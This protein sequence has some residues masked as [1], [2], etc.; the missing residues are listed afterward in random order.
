LR[1]PSIE[2]GQEKFLAGWTAD[3]II[4]ARAVEAARWDYLRKNPD[5]GL[6]GTWIERFG[7][8]GTHIEVIP[9]KRSGNARLCLLFTLSSSQRNGMLTPSTL[10]R[11]TRDNPMTTTYPSRDTNFVLQMQARHLQGR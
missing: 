5:I 4:L 6:C 7:W 11:K 9:P 8:D 3:N 1:F 10:V 2:G